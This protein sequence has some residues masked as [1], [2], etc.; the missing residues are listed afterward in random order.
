MDHGR[1]LALDTADELK[2]SIDA[3]TIVTVKAHGDL[4]PLATALSEQLEALHRTRVVD[5]GLELYVTGTEHLLPKVVGAAERAGVD[6]V[7]LSVS[8]PT[9]ETVFIAL[10]GKDLRD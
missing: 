7:D 8:A 6:L 3:D 9:L 4:G 1:I 5:G 2:R 10:T